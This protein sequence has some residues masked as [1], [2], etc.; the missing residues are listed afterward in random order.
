SEG[1]VAVPRRAGRGVEDVVLQVLIRY[2]RR[3]GQLVVIVLVLERVLQTVELIRVAQRPVCSIQ[4][5]SAV[6]EDAAVRAERE[7]ALNTI[8]GTVRAEDERALGPVGEQRIDRLGVRTLGTVTRIAVDA[9]HEQEAARVGAPIPL[10]VDVVVDLERAL[11]LVGLEAD[12]HV[13]AVA[14]IGAEDRRNA[15]LLAV[16]FLGHARLEVDIEAF[17]I[18]P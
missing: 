1:R 14:E 12:R 11:A 4:T 2:R 10:L 9:L 5:A 7:P 6:D 3:S 15:R 13:A 18:V 16:A 17:E 8:L